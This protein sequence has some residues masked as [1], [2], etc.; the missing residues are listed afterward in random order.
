MPLWQAGIINVAGL[1]EAGRGAWAGPVAAA[2]VIL[3]H[4]ADISK[5]LYGVRDSKQMTPLQR[6]YWAE[7]IKERASAWGVGFSSNQEIDALGIMAATRLAMMRALQC[8]L[9]PP[10]HLLIDAVKLVD[11]ELPQTV[12]VRGDQYSLSIAAASVIAKTARDSLMIAM[13]Q[14]YPGYHFAR[15]KGYG[16][17]LHREALQMLSP[18]ALHRYSFQPVK[19]FLTVSV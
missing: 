17:A 1:D 11:S 6:S 7:I 2:S 12:M 15:H 3:P 18:C 4:D 5:Y 9:L 16:T 10:R 14:E 13:E 8:M 19:S